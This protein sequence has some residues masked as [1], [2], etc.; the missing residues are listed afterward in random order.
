MASAG[1]TPTTAPADV[2]YGPAGKLRLTP[3]EQQAWSQ[4][5][6]QIMR[7]SATPFVNSPQFQQMPLRAQQIALQR[8]DQAAANAADKMVLWRS[9]NCP[10][11]RNG[12]AWTRQA[13]PIGPPALRRRRASC[14]T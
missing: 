8:I 9:S 14:S 1:V 3:D 7:Q 2:P 12:S 10:H 5:R 6:G 13:M 4:Y 11:R